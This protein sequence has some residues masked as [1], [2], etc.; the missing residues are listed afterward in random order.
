VR[1]LDRLLGPTPL[2]STGKD[3]SRNHK[4]VFSEKA[5]FF[6]PGC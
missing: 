5:G 2:S 3:H 1:L 6:A 4:P